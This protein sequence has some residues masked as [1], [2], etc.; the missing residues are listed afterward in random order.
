MPRH[1]RFILVADSRGKF[2]VEL[3]IDE[4]GGSSIMINHTPTQ[5]FHL[6]LSAADA[7]Q[8]AAALMDF[9]DQQ[10]AA[11]AAQ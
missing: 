8:L 9:A 1:D 6:A 4:D 11:E 5:A 2:E 3:F 7:R 10:D